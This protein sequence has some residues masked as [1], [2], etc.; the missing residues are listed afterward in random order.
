MSL[1]AFNGK[2]LFNGFN[3]LNGNEL[4]I[5]DGS[6]DEFERTAAVMVPGCCDAVGPPSQGGMSRV[7]HR[8][9]KWRDPSDGRSTL[10]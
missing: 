6:A 7:D 3:G 8:R 10:R 9:R 4:W 5:S 2:L 1:T